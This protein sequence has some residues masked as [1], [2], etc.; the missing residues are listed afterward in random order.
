[1]NIFSSYQ[2]MP[3]A[4][5]PYQSHTGQQAMTAYPRTNYPAYLGQQITQML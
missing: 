4:G 2:T 1:M 5:I 3:N